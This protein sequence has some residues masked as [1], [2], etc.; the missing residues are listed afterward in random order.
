MFKNLMLFALSTKNPLPSVGQMDEELHKNPFAPCESLQASSAGWVPP[1]GYENGP[2]VESIN[3]QWILTAMLEEKTVPSDV[4]KRKLKE[5]CD[6]IEK[7]TGRRPGRQLQKDIKTQIHD[8]LI[9]VA[10]PRQKAVRVW[11]NPQNRWLMI[12]ETSAKTAGVVIAMLVR[13]LSGAIAD[14]ATQTSPALAMETWLLDGDP[15]NF[16]VDMDYRL[17]AENDLQTVLSYAR[18]PL[19]SAPEVKQYIEHGM[20]PVQVALTWKNRVSFVL[21]DDLKIKRIKFRDVVFEGNANDSDDVFDADVAIATG[22]LQPMLGDLFGALDGIQQPE[23][24]VFEDE[25]EAAEV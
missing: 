4:V 20:Y 5:R 6:K 19:D 23:M 24:P 7:E 3:G 18:H 2:L 25:E 1:R 8:E 11:L 13:A 15:E 17:K 16:T 22:E 21:T 12:D 9:K 10:F 14:I